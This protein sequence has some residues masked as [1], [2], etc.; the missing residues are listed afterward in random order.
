MWLQPDG[1]GAAM[2]QGTSVRPGRARLRCVLGPQGHVVRGGHVTSVF[3]AD[4][5]AVGEA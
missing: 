1:D 3:R 2:G 5:A 4:G